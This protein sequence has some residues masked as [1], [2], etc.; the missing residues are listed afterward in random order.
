MEERNPKT[1]LGIALASLGSR[2]VT[3]LTL[4]G[5]AQTL[6]Q[7]SQQIDKSEENNSAE[8]TTTNLSSRQQRRRAAIKKR[9]RRLREKQQRAKRRRFLSIILSSAI[10]GL[11]I[12]SSGISIYSLLNAR[13]SVAPSSPLDRGNPLSTLFTISNDSSLA[14]NDVQVD[15]HVNRIFDENNN[16]IRDPQGNI[17]NAHYQE[18]NSGDKVNFPCFKQMFA[19]SLKWTGG[20]IDFYISFRPSFYPWR[21][22]RILK[23]RAENGADGLHWF[24][25]P[26]D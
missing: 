17:G 3:L 7:P 2:A 4:G 9:R 16:V 21:Q 6:R 24:Q 26:L 14:I 8:V 22:E 20:D 10:G 18:I 13:I 11:G 19:G 23:F 1:K 15:C 25:Q 5:R 12:I